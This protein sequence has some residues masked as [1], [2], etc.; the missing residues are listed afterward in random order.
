MQNN[1]Q[2][3]VDPVIHVIRRKRVMLDED[4]AKLYEVETKVLNQAV[5]RNTDR[6][7][8]EFMFQL[9]TDEFLNLKSQ[10]VTSSWGGRRKKPFAFTEHGVVMLASVLR[11]KQAIQISI[12]IVKAFVR[13]RRAIASHDNVLKQLSEVRTFMLKQSSK[14]D[15]GFRKVWKAIEDITAPSGKKSNLIGFELE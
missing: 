4:L 9:S 2:V 14:T 7:P 5:R 6:F 3:Q 10:F 15:Q 11:S 12:E 13:M 8:S 1:N